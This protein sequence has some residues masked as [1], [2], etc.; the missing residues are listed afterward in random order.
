MRNTKLDGALGQ[1][2]AQ[3]RLTKR[4]VIEFEV[5]WGAIYVPTQQFAQ[6]SPRN[7]ETIAVPLKKETVRSCLLIGCE[8]CLESTKHCLFA[9]EIGPPDVNL[10]VPEIN[11]FRLQIPAVKVGHIISSASNSFPHICSSS[12]TMASLLHKD[13]RRARPSIECTW[14]C[15]C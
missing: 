11:Q 14:A 6:N 4:A 3:G 12:P 2:R 15:H 9:L 13:R 7:H 8:C 5:C 10:A 1:L